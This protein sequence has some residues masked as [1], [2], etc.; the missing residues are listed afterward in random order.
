MISNASN[1]EG[2]EQNLHGSLYRTLQSLRGRP[3]GA[4]MR[5]LEAW[6]RLDRKSY[7]DLADKHLREALAYAHKRV[8]I[9]ATGRWAEAL[10][11]RDPLDI[12]SWPVLER[13]A[14]FQCAEQ[15]LARPLVPATN[16][17]SSASTG[18]PLNIAWD[19]RASAWNW[20]NEYRS[21]LWHGV[22]IGTRTLILWHFGDWFSNF[23]LNRKLFVTKRLTNE[24]LEAAARHLLERRP[25]LL[26]GLPSAVAQLARYMGAKYPHETRPLALFAKIGGEQVFPFQREEISRYLGAR[27]IEV[28]GCSESGA[29]AMECP[30]GSLHVFDTNVHLEIFRDGKPVPLGEFGDIVATSLNNKAMPLVRCR[31]GDRGRLSPDPC[32]C[33]LHSPVLMDLQGRAADTFQTSDGEMV[34]GSAIG[35]GMDAYVGRPPLGTVQLLKFQQCDQ[36]YWQVFAQSDDPSIAHALRDQLSELIQGIFGKDCRIDLRLVDFIP[37]ET[38]GKYRYY[39]PPNKPGL[40]FFE[41]RAEASQETMG[42]NVSLSGSA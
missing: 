15:F 3:V 20:A 36:R 18:D 30:A 11:G 28:Y 27:V 22:P 37:R 12:R 4:F 38:S 10:S 8:P 40:S 25:K 29:I 17:T 5:R 42:V 41:E 35:H 7:Q 34:H 9:Y 2:L 33:G 6:E 26:W 21:L 23:V 24:Q 14:L 31:I 16:R 13:E 1:F 19:R 32:T 39:I